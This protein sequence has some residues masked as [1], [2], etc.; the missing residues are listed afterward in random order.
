M[1]SGRQNATG[2]GVS[3]AD[4]ATD[5]MEGLRKQILLSQFAMAT[6]CK[7]EQ[8]QQFLQNAQWQLEVRT[9]QSYFVRLAHFSM[10][11]CVVLCR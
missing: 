8:A 5:G 4:L 2:G 9:L 11:K 10:V 7:F 1:L 6:G 3:R